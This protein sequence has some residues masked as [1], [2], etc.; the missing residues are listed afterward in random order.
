[1]ASRWGDNPNFS[2]T[3]ISEHPSRSLGA[4]SAPA[5]ALEFRLCGNVKSV[6]SDF[7]RPTEFPAGS[8]RS[9][10]CGDLTAEV[11]FPVGER[12]ELVE[13]SAHVD[14]SRHKKRMTKR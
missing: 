12:A 4:S 13:A 8:S 14:S 5:I 2:D 7:A 1:M 3:N 11:C 10:P 6:M 9:L